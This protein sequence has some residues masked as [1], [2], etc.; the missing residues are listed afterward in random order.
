MFDHFDILAPVYERVI[1]PPEPTRLK[2]LLRLPTDG[3]LLDAGGGT[4]RVAATLRPFVGGLI[5]GDL[6]LR[7]LQHARDKQTLHAVRAQV[8]RLPFADGFFSRILVVD[9]LHHFCDQ[10]AAAR[11]LARVLAPGGRL[12]I[13]EPD[14][15]R[16]AVKLVALAERMALMGS[17]FLTPEGVC[18][19]LTAQ[20]LH[21]HIADRDR[22][23]AWIVADK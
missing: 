21:A 20:G 7:M 5:V 10:P 23:S 9:A 14:I 15:H 17:T 1:A 11:E 2:T 18:D 6:S 8:Q 4:G 19:M 22:F 16:P 3:W 12:V 13:E